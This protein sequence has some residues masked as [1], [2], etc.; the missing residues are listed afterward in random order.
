MQAKNTI[1][2]TKTAI[3][4]LP[5]PA[6]VAASYGDESAPT[7]LRL[8]IT[9]T[10]ARAWYWMGRIK[11]QPESVKIGDYADVTPERAKIRAREINGDAAAGVS[12]NTAKRKDRTAPTMTDLWTHYLTVQRVK[13]RTLK[14]YTNNFNRYLAPWANRR[15]SDITKDEV[16]RLHGRIA[17]EKMDRAAIKE[18]GRRIQGGTT[19]ANRT[20]ALLSILFN[21][22]AD[23]FGL[24]LNPARGVKRAKESPRERFLGEAEFGPFMQAVDFLAQQDGK[25]F[26]RLALFTGQRRAN[27][28]A[29][30][31]EDIN[32]PFA[33]WTLERGEMKG[34][35]GHVVPLVG[36]ALDILNRRQAAAEP[37]A[38]WVFPTGSATGHITE[39]KKSIITAAKAAGIAALSVHDLRR[40]CATWLNSTG[41]S[42]GTIAALLAHKRQSVT[43]AVYVKLSLDTVRTAL[44]KAVQAMQA[45]AGVVTPAATNK[46]SA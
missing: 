4:A 9:R 20:L 42:E 31:W 3:D 32:I 29:M 14:D 17:D 2:F 25:D 19:T 45:A 35:H 41:A 12:P 28:Q 33:S 11:G 6:E 34:G 7:G 5:I 36:A 39:P 21:A 1:K 43:G 37:G 22:G 30:K 38:V 23:E 8:R 27:L 46:A 13:D 40:T 26:I 15:L 24:T 44:E 16:R 10:G 18:K